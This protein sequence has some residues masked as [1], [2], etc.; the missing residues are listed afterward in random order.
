M[1][2]TDPFYAMVAQSL[3]KEIERLWTK[4]DGY[5]M[6][7][8]DT[9]SLSLQLGDATWAETTVDSVDAG[10]VWLSGEYQKIESRAFDE[11]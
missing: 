6:G 4:I 11:L 7:K 2:E 3:L 5:N 8:H 1:T 10:K 9:L